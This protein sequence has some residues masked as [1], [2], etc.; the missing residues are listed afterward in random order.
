VE[1]GEILLLDAPRWGAGTIKMDLNCGQTKIA[2]NGMT[3]VENREIT[4][5]KGLD[6]FHKELR[7]N[8]CRVEE[9]HGRFPG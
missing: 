7:F 8:P 3:W 2:R 6:F 4:K 1:K 5:W 9:I